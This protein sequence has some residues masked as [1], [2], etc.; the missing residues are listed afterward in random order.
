M[1]Y[2]IGDK[3]IINS[4]IEG[5]YIGEEVLIIDIEGCEYLVQEIDLCLDECL[6]TG[7]VEEDEIINSI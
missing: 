2:N 5:F 7:Y 1:K 4:N 3:V 6:S